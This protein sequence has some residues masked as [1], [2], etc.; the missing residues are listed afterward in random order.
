MP[1]GKTAATPGNATSGQV[2]TVNSAGVLAREDGGTGAAF[3]SASNQYL[4]TNAAGQPGFHPLQGFAIPVWTA[5]D[6]YGINAA[7]VASTSDNATIYR[8]LKANNNDALSVNASW[9]RLAVPPSSDPVEK[10]DIDAAGA[11]EYKGLF[12][13]AANDGLE[14]RLITYENLDAGAGGTGQVLTRTASGM[15]WREIA[16]T[17]L[18]TGEVTLDKLDISGTGEAGKVIGWAAGPRMAWVTQTGGGGGGLVVTGTKSAGKIPKVESDGTSVSWQDDAGGFPT[19]G[20]ADGKALFATGTGANDQAWETIPAELPTSGKSDGKILT[21]TGINAGDNAWEDAPTGIPTANKASGKVLTA[22]GT[23]ASDQAWEDPA[24]QTNIV[25]SEI[26]NNA[27]IKISKISIG[28]SLADGRVLTGTSGTEA[29]WEDPVK[30]LPASGNADGKVLTGTGTGVGD[31]AWE[32]VPKELPTANKADGKA[33]F[34]TG[35]GAGDNAWE[36]VPAALP[37]ANKADGKILTATGSGADAHAWEDPATPPRQTNIVNSEISD[38]AAIALSKLNVSGTQSTGKIIKATS[39]T[40]ASWQDDSGGSGTFTPATT[41]EIRAGTNNAKGMTPAGYKPLLDETTAFRNNVYQSDWGTPTQ[42]NGDSTPNLASLL[43]WT[44]R[45]GSSTSTNITNNDV[46]LYLWNNNSVPSGAAYWAKFLAGGKQWLIGPNAS[47]NQPILY[48]LVNGL[49]LF[50]N[51]SDAAYVTD[52]FDTPTGG[53]WRILSPTGSNAPSISGVGTRPMMIRNT[54]ANGIEAYAFFYQGTTYRAYRIRVSS[55]LKISDGYI[56]SDMIA[57]DAINQDKIADDSIRSEHINDGAINSQNMIADRTISTL[58]IQQNAVDW[59]EIRDNAVI[60][61]KINNS[62]VTTPKIN[63]SA[64]SNA[65]LANNS[66]DHNKISASGKGNNKYLAM[67]ANSSGLAFVDPPSSSIG[68][69]AI[70]NSNMFAS[71]V[72]NA[73]AIGNGAVGGSELAT[74]AINNSN[75]FASGVVNSQCSG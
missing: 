41:A 61:S 74:G 25:D 59:G 2:P 27:A 29:S 28:G 24:R 23:G 42:F 12:L 6:S 57:A 68:A 69:G 44:Y 34:A 7:V 22:K 9:Q 75:K 13:N 15:A 36:D 32:D 60:T 62:A 64:V 66:V 58:K 21:A 51:D 72:V 19:T 70:N 50:R 71:G 5:N 45:T 38:S 14:W 3:P 4:G 43:G 10:D 1:S 37:T 35:T 39:A 8:S 48:E 31:V 55:G 26:A 30:E 49:W 20:K 33:L 54:S 67:N 73:S 11:A 56:E 16:A 63:N 18:G 53:A 52:A 40:A 17:S 65:K 46:E 47:T